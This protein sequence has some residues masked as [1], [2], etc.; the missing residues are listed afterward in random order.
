MPKRARAV[1]SSALAAAVLT[2]ALARPASA[3]A[4]P[5]SGALLWQMAVAGLVG[6]LFYVRRIVQWIMRRYDRERDT[7]EKEN[8]L[9]DQIRDL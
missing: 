9:P 4:D 7:R 8:R 3:Y 5:G 1:S 2:I 6:G